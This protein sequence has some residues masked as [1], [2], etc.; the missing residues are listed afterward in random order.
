MLYTRIGLQS[1]NNFLANKLQQ[2]HQQPIVIFSQ[3]L[4]ASCAQLYQD[5][6]QLL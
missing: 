3:P 2:Y 1:Y 4:H 6:A 5:T